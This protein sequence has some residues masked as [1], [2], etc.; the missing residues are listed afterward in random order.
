M[1]EELDQQVHWRIR[2]PLVEALRKKAQEEKR[3][4]TAQVELYIEAGLK[5]KAN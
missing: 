5:A 2:R 1:T 4:V 3:T